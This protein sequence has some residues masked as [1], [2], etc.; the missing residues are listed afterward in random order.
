MQPEDNLHFVKDDSMTSGL[1]EV[2]TRESSSFLKKNTQQESLEDAS[3][4]G[5]S[6]GTCLQGVCYQQ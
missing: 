3:T 6:F 2:K 5:L 4:P 1:T